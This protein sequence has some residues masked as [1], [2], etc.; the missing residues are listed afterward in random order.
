MQKLK[1]AMV[2]NYP[3]SLKLKKNVE[4]VILVHY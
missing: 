2:F 4:N 1:T 3:V